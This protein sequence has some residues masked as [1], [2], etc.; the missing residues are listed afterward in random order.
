M[1]TEAMTRAPQRR[2]VLLAGAQ[3]TMSL[4][5]AAGLAVGCA[6]RRSPAPSEPTAQE[7]A[8]CDE[9]IRDWVLEQSGQ[10]AVTMD[11]T[12][13]QIMTDFD[14]ADSHVTVTAS[15]AASVE[16]VLSR[17]DAKRICESLLKSARRS[18][19]SVASISILDL[20]GTVVVT[21]GADGV[22][23]LAD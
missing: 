3:L 15:V 12:L 4:L 20:G 22:C 17:G 23:H 10:M 5:V 7:C 13:A 19:L 2:S 16:G 1:M 8:S 18:E 21:G 6:P 9:Q 11:H 14:V